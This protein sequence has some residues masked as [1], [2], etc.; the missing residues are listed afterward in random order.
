MFSEGDCIMLS[1][2]VIITL[3]MYTFEL[4]KLK[5]KDSDFDVRFLGHF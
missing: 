2:R 4:S 5:K 1:G 3:G